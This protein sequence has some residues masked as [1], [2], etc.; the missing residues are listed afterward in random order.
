MSAFV[1]SNAH[2]NLLVNSGLDRVHF[3]HNGT[4]TLPTTD[5]ANSLG[6][7]LI[8][9]NIQSVAHRYPDTNITDLP[10]ENNA[11]YLIPFA[12]TADYEL[13][14]VV[15]RLKAIDCYEYQSC[16]HPDWHNSPAERYCHMLRKYLIHKLRDYDDAE[17][18]WNKSPNPN[19]IR[20][21]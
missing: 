8:D 3:D 16:E 10:G 15:Q 14:S 12:F 1:L 19:I 7:M 11:N 17:W 5:N 13:P 20:I 6:Q 9:T 2:I 4:R 21:I 18:D